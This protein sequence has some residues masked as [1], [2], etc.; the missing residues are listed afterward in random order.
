ME[1]ARREDRTLRVILWVPI[2]IF[3]PTSRLLPL[4]HHAKTPVTPLSQ[5]L[6]PF[7]C[8]FFG[9]KI[10]PWGHSQ[11]EI[12]TRKVPMGEHPSIHGI[13]ACK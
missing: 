1:P 11:V 3:T 8:E 4:G 10:Y 2:P 7:L 12:E 5:H 6:S 9:A 13:K